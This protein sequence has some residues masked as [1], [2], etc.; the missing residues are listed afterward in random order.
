MRNKLQ[1]F[2]GIPELGFSSQE[3]CVDSEK[4]MMNL[5]KELDVKDKLI[6]LQ[7]KK[8]IDLQTKLND[9]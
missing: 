4:M 7:M 2:N 8:I 3:T 5:K 6:E 1:K 9:E